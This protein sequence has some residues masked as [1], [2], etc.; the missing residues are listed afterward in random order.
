MT[1]R[2]Q[3]RESR[4][5]TATPHWTQLRDAAVRLESEGQGTTIRI[6]IKIA[7]SEKDVDKLVCD[8]ARDLPHRPALHDRWNTDERTRVHMVRRHIQLGLQWE[9]QAGPHGDSWWWHA[10]AHDRT[11]RLED[12]VRESVPAATPAHPLLGTVAALLRTRAGRLHHAGRDPMREVEEGIRR[13]ANAVEIGDLPDRAGLAEARRLHLATRDARRLL[14]AAQAIVAALQAVPSLPVPVRG[15]DLR[16]SLGHALAHAREGMGAH[17]EPIVTDALAGEGSHRWAIE[18]LDAVVEANPDD[19]SA[20]HA[21]AAVH[22][23]R[24]RR[25]LR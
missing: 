16:E 7:T 13:C 18:E 19:A 17:V 8:S 20:R 14:H 11:S 15:A 1:E 9:V 23:D 3:A 10:H 12:R 6:E 5:H 4:W 22:L 25:R 24:A 2:S 21:L